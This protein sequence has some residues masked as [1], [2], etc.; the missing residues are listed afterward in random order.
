MLVGQGDQGVFRHCVRG[1]L[2][3]AGQDAARP[4]HLRRLRPAQI[5][6][7]PRP[8][9]HLSTGIAAGRLIRF[10][11]PRRAARVLLWLIAIPVIVYLA[12]LALMVAYQRQ[13]QYFP[14][15]SRPQ[16][17]AL[18]RFGLREA[19]LRTADGLN[20]LSWY[21]APRQ[22]RPAILYCHGNGGH[23]GYRADRISPFAG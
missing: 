23:I 19:T 16:L 5:R 20:L 15:R 12:V 14:D 17:G 1:R 2:F 7:R 10:S 21:L 8:P 22:G 18:T 13:L 9:H 6:Q 3:G 11:S 4:R